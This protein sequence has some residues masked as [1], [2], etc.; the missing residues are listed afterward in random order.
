VRRAPDTPCSASGTIRT[1][2]QTADALNFQKHRSRRLIEP[3]AILDLSLIRG[4]REK[5]WEVFVK[6]NMEDRSKI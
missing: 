1:I 5:I 6:K 2:L 3:L 4:S